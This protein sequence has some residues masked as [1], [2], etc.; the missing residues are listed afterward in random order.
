MEESDGAV[1]LK[2]QLPE[3]SALGDTQVDVSSER[4]VLHAP[5]LYKLDL[6]WPVSGGASDEAKAKF[7]KKSRTLTVTMPLV[8]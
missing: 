6:P 4:F 5:G 3:L 1:T 2:V 8:V 7:A